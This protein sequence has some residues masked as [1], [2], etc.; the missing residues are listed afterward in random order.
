M[1]FRNILK[2]K[3]TNIVNNNFTFSIVTQFFL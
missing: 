3:K 2:I 1:K